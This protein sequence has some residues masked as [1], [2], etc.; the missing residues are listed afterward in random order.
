MAVGLTASAAGLALRAWRRRARSDDDDALP[1][2]AW[3]LAMFVIAAAL[4]VAGTVA[5]D[6]LGMLYAG[7]ALIAALMLFMGDRGALR[8]VLTSTLPVALV[9]LMARYVLYAPLP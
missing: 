2:T 3:N 1:I 6:Y 7:P 5:I 8:I 9:Y 4:A